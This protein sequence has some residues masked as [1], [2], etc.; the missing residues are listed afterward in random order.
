MRWFLSVGVTALA[1]HFHTSIPTLI[2]ANARPAVAAVQP[3]SEDHRVARLGRMCSRAFPAMLT[4][5]PTRRVVQ[6]RIRC[7]AFP[8]AR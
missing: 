4:R 2:P 1:G 3:V 7:R 8:P 5:L 6:G